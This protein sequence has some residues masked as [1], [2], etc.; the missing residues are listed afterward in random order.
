MKQAELE[1]PLVGGGFGTRH[2]FIPAR[3]NTLYVKVDEK[4]FNAN[5]YGDLD[6]ISDADEE[7]LVFDG[8]APQGLDVV[9]LDEFDKPLP[10]D[11]KPRL[12]WSKYDWETVVRN[13]SNDDWAQMT[14]ILNE[15][16]APDE[17]KHHGF[18][19]PT[20]DIIPHDHPVNSQI[21]SL[22]P[23]R[24]M[25]SPTFPPGKKLRDFETP[26]M[27]RR[28]AEVFEKHETAGTKLP[29]ALQSVKSEYESRKRR[30]QRPTQME[31]NNSNIETAPSHAPPT[32]DEQ[33]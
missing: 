24:D 21:P 18:E 28:I 2:G 13:M 25:S 26:T 4:N 20:T 27:K 6:N 31:T 3:A 11:A 12:D 1:D 32:D 5:F 14:D 7:A 19:A 16:Y 29:P 22:S 10:P 9:Y 8:I 33:K 30:R 15:I 23:D 17:Q